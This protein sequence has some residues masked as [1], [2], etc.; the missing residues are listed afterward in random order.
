ML[1]FYL[2]IFLSN[3]EFRVHTNVLGERELAPGQHL[4][5]SLGFSDVHGERRIKQSSR[6]RSKFQAKDLEWSQGKTILVL[7]VSLNYF[8]CDKFF[9]T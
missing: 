2:S 6:G 9:L 8:M 3:I 5:K 7:V 4:C 1:R